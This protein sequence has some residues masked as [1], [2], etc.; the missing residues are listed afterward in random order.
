MTQ[1]ETKDSGERVE[2][3]SGMRRD[4]E[5]GKPRFDLLRPP[6]VPYLE[7]FLT[8]CAAL[9]GRGADKYGDRNWE[10]ANSQA[11]L[12]RF[13]SSAARH[14]E[15]WFNGEEDEDHA[16]AVF[17]N[18]LAHET[19]EYK[20]AQAAPSD[21]FLIAPVGT[22]PTDGGWKSLGFTTV[23]GI[24][25]DAGFKRPSDADEIRSRVKRVADSMKRFADLPD[26]EPP[27]R[28]YSIRWQ[29]PK[30]FVTFDM[31]SDL[32]PYMDTL[33][34]HIKRLADYYH[35]T[36]PR[37]SAGSDG[38]VTDRKHP[39]DEE[40]QRANDLALKFFREAATDVAAPT[41]GEGPVVIHITNPPEQR[42][43]DWGVAASDGV[44]RSFD[45]RRHQI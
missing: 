12:E 13:K 18:L 1:Y 27:P 17:F 4:V 34:D 19:I 22:E 31:E 9:L 2:F 42:D 36:A 7:Q 10:K 21:S 24:A 40:K 33:R 20:M 8:R 11:E 15:Q 5:K 30:P 6:G 39:V 37:F 35:G 44:R 41:K 38:V 16:A 23:D 43:F 28:D 3:D 25:E 45:R 14:F 26:H 32:P 29:T